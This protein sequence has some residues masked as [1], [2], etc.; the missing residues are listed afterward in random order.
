MYIVDEL[1]GN[2]DWM[3]A[4][5]KDGGEEGYIPRNYVAEYMSDIHKK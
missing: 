3:Y 1:N 5:K 4:C 2:D